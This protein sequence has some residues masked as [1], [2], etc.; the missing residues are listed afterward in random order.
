M[1]LFVHLHVF[2]LFSLFP[3]SIFSCGE[4]I[5]LFLKDDLCFLLIYPYWCT[6]RPLCICL[7]TFHVCLWWLCFLL[8]FQVVSFWTF[9]K[10][11][12]FCV[13]FLIF[14]LDCGHFVYICSDIFFIYLLSLLFFLLWFSQCVKFCL[15]FLHINL[16]ASVSVFL[17]V[18]LVEAFS[19]KL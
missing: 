17:S 8:T 1:S 13:S 10:K 3:F 5:S 12:I 2:S 18:H 4:Y 16:L 11:F 19:I 9:K 6:L 7:W 15:C 14:A